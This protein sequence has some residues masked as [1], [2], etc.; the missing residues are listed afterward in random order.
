MAYRKEFI[1]PT[2][3]KWIDNNLRMFLNHFYSKE[4]RTSIR[5]YAVTHTM[6]EI[7]E[8]N[9]FVL[10]FNIFILLYKIIAHNLF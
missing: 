9:W 6:K 7:Y 3:Y 5:I 1:V 2:Q 10:S 4:K 8:Q